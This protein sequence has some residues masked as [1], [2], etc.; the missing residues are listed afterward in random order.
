MNEPEF[1]TKSEFAKLIGKSK[2][3]VSMMFARG[4]LSAA[5]M[6]G[7]KIDVR[8]AR[9]AIAAA[10]DPDR[11]GPPRAPLLDFDGSDE[12]SVE[13]ASL[14][15][16]RIDIAREKLRREQRE[17]DEA[18][19]VLVLAEEVRATAMTASRQ[20]RDAIMGIPARIAGGIAACGGDEVKIQ[21]ALREAISD[22][23]REI[24]EGIDAECSQP[25]EPT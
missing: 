2:S 22:A 25:E 11:P 13:N 1:A 20:I 18:E 15:A 5:V 17:N 8:A 6:H 9:M 21:A 10:K 7:E 14:T 24:A 4:T 16:I 19:G 23:L 12:N 3:A